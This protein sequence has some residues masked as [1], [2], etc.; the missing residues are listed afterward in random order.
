MISTFFKI[1]SV[2]ILLTGLLAIMVIKNISAEKQKYINE[3][4]L[5]LR[6]EQ[7][8]NELY[9]IEWDHLVSPINIKKISEMI[10]TN[11]YQKYFV[12]LDNEDIEQNNELFNDVIEI[13][14]TSKINQNLAR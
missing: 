5:T 6:E 1:L 14:D 4:E 12:V 11:D 8:K 9:K 7:K 3:L 2:T 10:I 13:Y